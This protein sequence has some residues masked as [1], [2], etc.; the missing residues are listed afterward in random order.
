MN[1]SSSISPRSD[2]GWLGADVG[3]LW[4]SRGALI[5][6]QNLK[7]TYGLK[8]V[9]RGIDLSLH[10]GERMALLGANGT[11]KT[12][13]LRVLAGL[14][15]PDSGNIKIAGLDLQRQM[16]EVRRLIGF[17]AHQPYLYGE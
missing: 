13:L 2:K 17:V 3:P 10:C 5:E 7:K 4:L 9:L 15:Q 12:T 16:Q 14:T 11:G 1:S 6:I 8:P